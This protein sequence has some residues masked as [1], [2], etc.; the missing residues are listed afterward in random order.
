MHGIEPYYN[1]RHHYIASEDE[2]SP[3]YG[4]E[5]SEIYFTHAIYNHVIHPQWDEIE[6]PTLFVKILFVDYESGI[7]IIELFGEWN[8]AINN[9]IMILRREVTDVLFEQGISKFI[10]IGENVLNFHYS[11]DSYYEDWFDEV[12]EEDGWIALLDFRD[13]VVQE[14]SEIDIDSYFVMGG[15]LDIV[16]WRA[17]EPLHLINMIDSYAQKRLGV[18]NFD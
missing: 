6:S 7:G 10:L 8:D 11:D 15:A 9:D 13:H 12:C 18:E 17:M 14:L 4:R 3:F 1:W 16:E 5:Y 2:R